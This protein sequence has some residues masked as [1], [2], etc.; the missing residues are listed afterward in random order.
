MREGNEENYREVFFHFRE[1]RLL[2][3]D[4]GRNMTTKGVPGESQNII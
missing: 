3:T 2:W 4:V 1:H